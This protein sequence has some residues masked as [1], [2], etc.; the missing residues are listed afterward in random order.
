MGKNN[1]YLTNQDL[2]LKVITH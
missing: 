1:V 2:N